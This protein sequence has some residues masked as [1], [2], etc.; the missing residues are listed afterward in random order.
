M[1]GIMSVTKLLLTRQI[2]RLVEASNADEGA[3]PETTD[4][5]AGGGLTS[6]D[7]TGNTFVF[8]VAGHET[9]SNSILHTCLL[10]AANRAAQRQ[11]QKDIDKIVQDK[12]LEQLGYE[13][14]YDRFANGMVGAV[15]HEQLRLLPPV[16]LIPKQVVTGDQ[17]VNFDGRTVLVPNG[18]FI[19][20]PA[21]ALH[22]NI[23]YWPHKPS[24]RTKKSHDLDDFVPTRW[25]TNSE[26]SSDDS[27]PHQTSRRAPSSH[28]LYNPPHGSFVPF[29]EGQRG[30]LGRRF[31]LVEMT[32]ALVSIFSRYSIELSVSQW[33]SDEEVAKMSEYE[34]A[35]LY[36]KAVDEAYRKLETG[37]SA[38]L[39]LQLDKG[40]EIPVR[41]VRRGKET[42][43]FD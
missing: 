42:A 6:S 5:K 24:A 2:A 17:T 22:R 30:C 4:T 36:Q 13:E 35:I 25:L 8:L 39:T 21:V 33:A 1:D 7:I 27:D 10:L 26:E 40:N 28:T 9:S 16:I 12:A 11:L 20:V 32:A 18:T 34:R 41:F 23:K 19:H 29:S 15:I 14:Y 43:G 31:A 38:R 37:A 3:Y